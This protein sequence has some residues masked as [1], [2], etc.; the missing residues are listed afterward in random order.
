MYRSRS[1]FGLFAAALYAAFT[2]ASGLVH[3]ACAIARSYMLGAVAVVAGPRDG[4]GF[5]KPTQLRAGLTARE[6]H[7][8]RTEAARARPTHRT[9]AALF[10]GAC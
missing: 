5:A 2:L 8:E 7:Y 1:I 9:Q 10:A 3:S 6:A 4:V